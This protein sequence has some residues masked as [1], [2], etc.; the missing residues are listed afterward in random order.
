MGPEWRN[1]PP[2]GADR[3]ALVDDCRFTGTT[4]SEL[5]RACEARGW[6]VVKEIVCAERDEG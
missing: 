1:L 2:P 3:V 4:L 6:V 5:R